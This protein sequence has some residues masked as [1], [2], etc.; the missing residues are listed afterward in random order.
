MTFGAVLNQEANEILEVNEIWSEYVEVDLISCCAMLQL[1][2]SAVCALGFRSTIPL[3]IY[4]RSALGP[5]QCNV[6]AAKQAVTCIGQ[7]SD[8]C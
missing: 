3:A 6:T 5:S 2:M 1:T 4:D 8:R 7:G